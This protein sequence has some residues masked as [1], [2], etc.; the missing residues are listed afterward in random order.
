MASETGAAPG[1][2]HDQLYQLLQNAANDAMAVINSGPGA[3]AP[4]MTQYLVSQLDPK[5]PPNYEV[6]LTVTGH[7]GP[8]SWSWGKGEK[9][10]AGTAF[11]MGDAGV[12]PGIGATY[13]V[14]CTV[15]WGAASQ[16]QPE[17]SPTGDLKLP[18]HTKVGVTALVNSSAEQ[19][20][21]I[22]VDGSP[23]AK[24]KGPGTQDKNLLTQ[25]FDTGSGNVSVDVEA[26]GKKSALVNG[27]Y[28]LKGNNFAYVLS[29]DGTD[30]DYND[31]I[32][33]FN[34]PLG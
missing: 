6:F 28:A 4:R 10:F 8:S 1:V 14:C 16:P 32:L 12:L 2:T 22:S 7:S 20:I 19:F 3:V 31:V 21:T 26:N 33:M 23:V 17:P 11:W 25:I 13:G 34:W 15:M 27:S 5:M 24:F 29:E 30:N 9:M 18:P